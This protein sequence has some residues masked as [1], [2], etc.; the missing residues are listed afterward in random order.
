MA[1]QSTEIQSNMDGKLSRRTTEQRQLLLEI[2]QQAE[3]H[4][5]ADEIYQRARQR[6]PSI[7]L[8]TVYRSL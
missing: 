8:S 6:L 1:G 5:D 4:L 3:G 7:S 2:I